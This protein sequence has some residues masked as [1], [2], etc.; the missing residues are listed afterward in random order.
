ML[1][2]GMTKGHTPFMDR[3]ARKVKVTVSLSSDLLRRLDS[4][5]K[6]EKQSRSAAIE[7]AIA[8]E[9]RAERKRQLDEEII[10]YYAQ[11]ESAED[12]AF[13]LALSKASIQALARSEAGDDDF[14]DWPGASV[15]KPRQRKRK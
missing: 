10:A 9:D 15:A 4:R 13:S 2:R 1:A 8:A 11:P 12:V 6:K 5:R 7:A 3:G 14:S